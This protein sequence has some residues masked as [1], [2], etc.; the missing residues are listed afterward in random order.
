M[1]RISPKCSQR[2]VCASR[3][4]SRQSEQKRLISAPEDSLRGA[5][6][7]ASEMRSRLRALKV[8]AVAAAAAP[9][10]A[11]RAR[12]SKLRSRLRALKHVPISA[13]EDSLRGEPARASESGG[14]GEAAPPPVASA[15]IRHSIKPKHLFERHDRRIRAGDV[16]AHDKTDAL[17]LSEV[18]TTLGLSEELSSRRSVAWSLSR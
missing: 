9:F 2:G 13:P 12:A 14:R 1:P 7:R 10:R 8:V 4:G 16:I 5:P 17:T 6:A 15:Q 18:L 3:R 11:A